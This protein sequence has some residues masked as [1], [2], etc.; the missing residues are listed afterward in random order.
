MRLKITIRSIFLAL[1][2]LPLAM[3]LPAQ[4][5]STDYEGAAAMGLALRRLGPTQ[6]VLM[7]AAHPDD[8]ST[9]ILSTLALGHGADVAYLSLTRGEGGQNGIGPELQEG[10]G[11]LRTEELLAARRLDGARQYFT[12]AYDY[13]FSKSDEEAFRHWPRDSILADV[14]AVIRDFRPDIIVSIFSGTERDGHGQHHVAGL[15]AREGYAAAGDPDRFPEQMAG[16]LEPHEPSA[17]YLSRWSGGDDAAV[18][19]PTGELD[20][21]FGR[22]HYQIAMASRSLHRS[23]DMGRPLT[24]GPQSSAFTFVAGSRSADPAAGLFAGLDTTLA[25]RAAGLTGPAN[26]SSVIAAALGSYQ[27]IVADIEDQF[28]PFAPAAMVPAL[29]AALGHLDAALV[30]SR[31]ADDTDLR[32]HIDAERAQVEDALW[33]AS[34]LILDAISD[35]ET[36]VPGQRFTVDLTIWNG[37]ALPVSIA[38]L[39][40][41]L[42]PGWTATPVDELPG[43][44]EPDDLVSR[45]FLVTVPDSVSPREPYFLRAPRQGDIYTWPADVA[46][47]VPFQPPPVRAQASVTFGE[48]AV[49]QRI[50]A[51]FRAVDRRQGESRRPVRLVPAVAVSADPGLAIVR[52][53][54]AM[55][56][57]TVSARLRAEAPDGIAGSVTPGVPDGWR[58]EPESVPVRFS[59]PGAEATVDFT[60]LP[61]SGATPGAY[62][63]ALP[64][65]AANGEDYNRGF[66]LV[67]YPHTRPRPLYAPAV[68]AVRV[69]DV[70][71]PA[72]LSVGYVAGPGDEVPIALEQLGVGL[73]QLGPAQ[74]ATG[75]LSRFD[76][77][78]TG[79][80]AYEVRPDLITH[81]RRLLDYARAGG[82]VIVQYNKYEYTQPDIAPYEVAMTRPHGRVTDETAP[83]TLLEP[84]HPVLDWPNRISDQDFDGWVHERGLYFLSEWDDA[85]QP[86][87]AMSD[88]GEEPLEGSLLIAPYGEGTYVYTGLAFFRQLP[89]GVPGAYRL[90]ANLLALGAG[91]D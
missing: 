6:R 33:R 62:G 8:E 43:R 32:I 30:A 65:A 27:R 17:L 55:A 47:G 2:A 87:L 48:T 75:D 38:N 81:N 28:D 83:V 37:G 23:Q 20:P 77:I 3:P 85:F 11:L 91:N 13:G 31:G 39:E 56:P 19:L 25:Q 50:D 73:E 29:T 66:Y 82:T 76:V 24:A 67:D 61:A 86:V 36:I 42:P 54:S 53:G 4:A 88:P 60:I 45:G 59:G 89:E 90:F 15:M 9:Q 79:I 10:L 26:G 49:N 51:T 71:L 84:R 78:V 70:D 69:L 44:L 12:R 18:R 35:G 63:I 57:F 7:I 72:D 22:S 52:S 80:R 1:A 64:F 46:V 68:V 41:V 34:G 5:P 74:L 14:V 58:A 21:L 16:G 40:P